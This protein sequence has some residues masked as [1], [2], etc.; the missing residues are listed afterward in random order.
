MFIQYKKLKRHI[1]SLS[2]IHSIISFKV[3]TGVSVMGITD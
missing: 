2:T 1:T 3:I